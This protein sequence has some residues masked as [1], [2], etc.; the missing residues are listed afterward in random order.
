MARV[1]VFPKV[2]PEG[3][4]GGVVLAAE[5]V[6]PEASGRDENDGSDAR[7]Y[8]KKKERVSR[9]AP[10]NWS[11]IPRLAIAVVAPT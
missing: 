7:V 4:G 11:T 6:G 9:C 5:V 10:A 8:R 2:L 1:L 3:D